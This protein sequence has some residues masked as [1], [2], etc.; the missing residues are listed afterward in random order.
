MGLRAYYHDGPEWRRAGARPLLPRSMNLSLDVHRRLHSVSISVHELE[1]RAVGCMRYQRGQGLACKLI[2]IYV[3]AALKPECTTTQTIREH[4]HCCFHACSTRTSSITT[5]GW[6]DRSMGK[7][8]PT[9]GNA[10]EVAP[11][12]HWHWIISPYHPGQF[13]LLLSPLDHRDI[14]SLRRR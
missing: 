12:M 5:I 10:H 14:E 8:V 6:V 11:A 13:C 2:G 7:A 9:V 3:L 1:F 4:D